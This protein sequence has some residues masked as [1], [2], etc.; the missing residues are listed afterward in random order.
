MVKKVLSRVLYTSNFFV[1]V[2][3][4]KDNFPF[5]K[6]EQMCPLS[7]V[8]LIINAVILSGGLATDYVSHTYLQILN[9]SVFGRQTSGGPVIIDERYAGIIRHS[10]ET[11]VPPYL[12][13]NIG[14]KTYALSI[15][16]I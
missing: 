1:R 16:V 7:N 3:Y 5:T 11:P 4:T 2:T 14:L 15:F 9:K 8:F 12:S 13:K 6:K 10:P